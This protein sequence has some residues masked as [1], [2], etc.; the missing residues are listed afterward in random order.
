MGLGSQRRTSCPGC[1]RR[2]ATSQPS[3]GRPRQKLLVIVPLLSEIERYQRALPAFAFKEPSEYDT[4][5]LR[6]H[7]HGKKFYDLVRLVENGE[8]IIT[9]HSL[10]SKMDRDL[11]AKLQ[12]AGYELI[13]DEVLET[14]TLYKGLSSYDR[15]ILFDQKMVDVDPDTW[16]LPV[17]SGTVGD[18][19][20]EF[21]EV[22]TLCE[23]GSLVVFR[24]DNAMG[25]PVRVLALLLEG[26]HRHVHVRCVPLRRLPQESR[27]H[28]QP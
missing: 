12:A 28:V 9:T 11:Y 8:N 24:E 5:K 7:G 25:V 15:G 18:Y 26:H 13:I 27:V 19:D 23:T 20:G 22:E 16:R 2:P 14:V 1:A 4:K 17:E 3:T 21:R 6:K 10:F